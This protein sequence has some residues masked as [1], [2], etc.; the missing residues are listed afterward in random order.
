MNLIY[1]LQLTAIKNVLKVS[2]STVKITE[3]TQ[4]FNKDCMLG[5]AEYPDKYFQ[6]AICDPPYGI[7]ESKRF[8]YHPNALQTY[9]PKKWDSEIPD[10]SYF[11]ELFRVSVNQII[12]GANYFTELL[13]PSAKWII[14]DKMQPEGIDQAMFEMAYNSQQ[15]IQAKIYRQSAQSNCN[16]ATNKYSAKQYERI[17]PTQKPV[18]LYKWLLKNYAKEGDKILDTHL[19]SGSSRIAAYDM[20]F[21]FTGFELD[22]DYFEAQEKRFKQHI[23]QLTIFK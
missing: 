4:V 14:W 1:R 13:P 6:L 17:H 12:F 2:L 3:M 9:K 18:A 5:M 11:N 7:G 10:Q 15:N 23:A 22:K 19:G 16:K 8:S 20:G 21:D